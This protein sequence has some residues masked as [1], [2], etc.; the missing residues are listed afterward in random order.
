MTDNVLA[1]PSL[2]SAGAGLIA[3]RGPVTFATAGALLDTGRTLFAAQRAVTVNLSEVS[4]VDSA[5]LALLLEWLRQARAER[6]AVVFQAVPD[7][8]LAIAR[9]SGVEELL[10]SGYS[11]VGPASPESS[12]AVLSGS[13]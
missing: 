6:R 7:K 12:G 8:L 2:T 13:A 10:T 11:P 4:D 3:V 1:G 5:G 9:L